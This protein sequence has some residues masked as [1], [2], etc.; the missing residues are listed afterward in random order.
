MVLFLASDESSFTTGSEFVIDGAP[1]C[2]SR[3]GSER[4]AQPLPR[5]HR[6]QLAVLVPEL[7]L[8]GHLIDRAGM[9]WCTQAFGPD[10]MTAVAIEVGRRQPDLHAPHAAGAG[11][12]GRRRRDDLQGLQL[13]IGARPSSWTSATGS[14]TRSTVASSSTTAAPCWTSS[15]SATASS[16]D[17][18]RHRGPDVRRDRGGHQPEGADAA[19]APAAPAPADRQPHCAWTVTIDGTPPRWSRSRRLPSTPARGAANVVLDPIDPADVGTPTTAATCSATST[20]RPSRT[21]PW[22][23]SPTGVPPDAPAQP[24]LR[25][26]GHRPGAGQAT[27][28]RIAL[29]QLVGH[30]GITAERLHRALGPLLDLGTRRRT[31]RG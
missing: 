5:S 13:D 23:A 16:G 27:T 8:T 31:P 6:E 25:P 2:T 29:S 30:A 24:V 14:T 12:R 18:P 15:R 19:G 20:S 22:R 7:L 11:V 17:V 28:R 4:R 1:S 21:L 9:P 3:R 26:R 10:G